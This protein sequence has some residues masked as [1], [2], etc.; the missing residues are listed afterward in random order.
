M[1]KGWVRFLFACVLDIAITFEW[2]RVPPRRIFVLFGYLL[3]ELTVLH[4]PLIPPLARLIHSIQISRCHLCA[5]KKSHEPFN[6]FPI[7][8]SSKIVIAVHG[9]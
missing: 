3:R 4:M 8:S 9:G 5:H 1:Q 6:P 7:H 2:T